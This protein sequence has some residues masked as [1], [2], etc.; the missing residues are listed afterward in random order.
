M[1][2]DLDSILPSPGGVPPESSIARWVPAVVVMSAI[3]GFVALAWYAY[4]AGTQSLNEDEV[5]VVEADKTPMKEKPADPGGMQ[6]PNQDKTIFETFSANGQAPAKVERVLPSPEEPMPKQADTSDTTT[7]VNQN[8]HSDTPAAQPGKPEQVIGAVDKK[9]DTKEA[10]VAAVI[11]DEKPVTN[12]DNIESYTRDKA[13]PAPDAKSAAPAVKAPV[14]VAQ[15]TAKAPVAAKAAAKPEV[16]TDVKPAKT[17]A[18]KLEAAKPVSSAKVQLGAYRSEKEAQANWTL[19]QK[20]FGELKDKTPIIVKADLGDK[21]IYY[22]LRVSGFAGAAEA[23]T[24][25]NGLSAKGQAC[26]LASN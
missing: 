2:D 8:V 22:R 17:A 19:L 15:N 23:K 14:A 25:C 21:G 24:L 3:I 9:Q 12:N 18:A 5:L 4:H 6:F 7:W 10:S 1:E 26:I 13:V 20:K 11:H 16:K